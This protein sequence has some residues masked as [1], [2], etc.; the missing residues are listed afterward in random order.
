MNKKTPLL[1]KIS[2]FWG[3]VLLSSLILSA[4]GNKNSNNTENNTVTNQENA[5]TTS[6]QSTSTSASSSSS[7]F[8][9][10]DIKLDDKSFGS[11][12]SIGENETNI[13]V[14][15]QN[16][17]GRLS[18]NDKT[19]YYNASGDVI[20]EVKY[21]ETGFK[22]RK[23]DGTLLWKIKVKENKVKVSDNA[24]NQNPYEIKKK[25]GRYKIKRMEKEY[26]KVTFDGNQVKIKSESGTYKLESNTDSY[27]YGVLV[28]DE[29]PAE[30]RMIIIA[31][32]L[33]GKK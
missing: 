21:K 23:P 12:A 8:T 26:G 33:K 1:Y 3:V 32:L 15:D 28:I 5:S 20:A 22:L 10:L 17:T 18:K 31:E 4:C 14:K 24:E 11:I 6:N 19:K 30:H 9:P 27:A 2:F 13:T 29:I 7:T 25:E 16:I